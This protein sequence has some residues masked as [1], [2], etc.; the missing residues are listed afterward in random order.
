M[1]NFFSSGML[2]RNIMAARAGAK[3]NAHIAEM[4]TAPAMVNANCR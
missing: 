2:F 4:Q 3:V 1:K